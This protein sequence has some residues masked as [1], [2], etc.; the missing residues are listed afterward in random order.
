V[1]IFAPTLP[2]HSIQWT[3][4]QPAQVNVSSWTGKR[5][6][7]ADVWHG[8]WRAHVEL[9]TQQG[10]SGAAPYIAFLAKVRGSLNTFKIAATAG[11]QNSNS[12]VQLAA[13]TAAGARAVNIFGMA[14]SLTAGQKVT[15]ND[16]LLQL[17]A[18]QEAS[19]WIYFEPPLREA[20]NVGTPVETAN[21]YAL[22]YMASQQLGY[23]IGTWRR[24]GIVF[25]VEEAVAEP[26]AASSAVSLDFKL[27]RYWATGKRQTL[28]SSIAGYAFTRTGTQGSV[29]S[30][31]DVN[32]YGANTP[33]ID[34]NGF[35]SYGAA[36][37]LLLQS[38]AFDNASWTKAGGTITSTS[39]L[40]PNGSFT[41]DQLTE[42]TTNGAHQVS[43]VTPSL[44][45]STTHSLSV[46][47]KRTAGTRNVGLTIQNGAGT[48]GVNAV[49]DL[50][51][52]AVLVGAT[53]GSGWTFVSASATFGATKG[54]WRVAL[55]FTTPSSAATAVAIAKMA[56]G[57]STF[58]TGDNASS[59]VLWQGQLL[60]GNFAD[61][62]PV[63]ATTTATASIGAS[64]LKVSTSLT[65]D[66]IAWAVINCPNT[67][68]SFAFTLSNGTD[69]E[70]IYARVFGG[71]SFE[72]D[73][74][75]GG[76]AQ[77][78]PATIG[79]VFSAGRNVLMVRRKNGIHS[80]ALKK[81]DGTIVIGADASGA[82][83]LPAITVVDIGAYRGGTSQINGRVEGFF[84]RNGTFTDADV[85]AILTAA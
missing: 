19:G 36:T 33:D 68:D 34:T 83:T 71:V 72:T 58:Y 64:S 52:G 69:S 82:A 76:V 85:T 41:A 38:Q 24:Y 14:T 26:I 5:T 25:D 56:S 31:G 66:F 8:K 57:S 27:Q 3:L 28:L 43:Q 55:V 29:N 11:A 16:Q 65:G 81:P 74:T 53:F 79:S 48:S 20:A 84:Q 32:F 70:R 62:G 9:A 30:G 80:I 40:D 6:A 73:V 54:Y 75:A 10:E 37:N 13:S 50:S 23:E 77:P 12:G 21:P 61:G 2:I 49:L 7:M 46:F 59:L 1:F 67:A 35:H 17:T 18:D 44:A 15:I 45:A 22:V 4:D 47:V 42:D 78:T 60:A 63:I 39:Q 51:T